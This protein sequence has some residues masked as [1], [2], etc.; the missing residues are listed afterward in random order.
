[1]KRTSARQTSFNS[2]YSFRTL[3]AIIVM[4]VYLGCLVAP[5]LSMGLS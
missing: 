2:R 3:R 5:P 1:M 4:L